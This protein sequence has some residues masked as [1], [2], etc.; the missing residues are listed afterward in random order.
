MME[1]DIQPIVIPI[2]LAGS[3]PCVV[4][5]KALLDNPY[6][7]QALTSSCLKDGNFPT[8]TYPALV[9]ISVSPLANLSQQKISEFF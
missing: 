9:C 5:I 8:I 7:P 6:P 4:S 1:A 2:W 3:L